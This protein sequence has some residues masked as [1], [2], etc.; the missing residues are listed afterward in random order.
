M[1]EWLAI[2]AVVVGAAFVPKKK[3]TVEGKI[4]RI[5]EN[6][7]A[8]IKQGDSMNYPRL[9][10][11]EDKVSHVT[12]S[13]SLPLGM[14]ADDAIKLLPAIRDGLN[15]EIEIEFTGVLL[16]RVFNKKLPVSWKYKDDLLQKGTWEVP[17]GRNHSGILYHD[18][19]KYPHML[20]GGV[21]RF[22]KTVFIKEAFYSLLMNQIENVDFY[23]LDLKG[24]MEFGEYIG[25]PQVKAV[26]SDIYE[27]TELLSDVMEQ[28]KAKQREMRAK[29]YKNIVDTPI[30]QR[31]FIIVDEGAELS[32]QIINGK[33]AK[34]YAAFCQAVL[35]EIARIGG[36]LGYRLIFCTQYPTREAVPMQIKANIVA[37]LSFIAAEQVGSRVILDDVGAEDLPSIPGRAIYKIEKN[38]TV[39]VPYIDDKYMFNK[40]EER[41]DAINHDE[42]RK[43]ANDNRHPW[44]SQDKTPAANPRP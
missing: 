18:F 4:Q 32:P 39:Q 38:R 10:N 20:V 34:K 29:R 8:G 19:D 17:V 21:T 31:T 27:S 5:F 2:P 24:G 3:L 7:N 23:I 1:L 15:K 37:R 16:I 26:A 9:L 30:N 33:E 6:T 42:N 12:Y 28:L 43:P 35:S 41:A 11:K 22:G 25:I 44:S 36:A 14:P 13:Y 40:M